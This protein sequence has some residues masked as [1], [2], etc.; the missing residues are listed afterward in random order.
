[1]KDDYEAEQVPRKQLGSGGVVPVT[2]LVESAHDE[3][4]ERRTLEGEM[5]HMGKD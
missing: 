1:M 2:K 5:K 3:Q 4:H